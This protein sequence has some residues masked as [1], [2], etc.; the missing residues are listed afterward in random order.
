MH[1]EIEF[2]NLIQEIHNSFLDNVMCFI[3]HLG[4]SGFIWI[5][6]AIILLF[7]RNTRKVGIVVLA[8]LILELILCNGILKNIFVRIRPCDIN[9]SIKLLIERP[10]DYSFPSGHTASSFATVTALLLCKMKRIGKVAL[11][12]AILIAFSRMYLYVHYP[13]DI[14]CG[15]VVGLI[16]GYVSKICLDRY[17]LC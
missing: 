15:I 2:L 10:N 9:T 8:A 14:L 17:K 7:K 4:D 5:I 12:L 3:T 1:W 16:C 6:L 11:L 13:T